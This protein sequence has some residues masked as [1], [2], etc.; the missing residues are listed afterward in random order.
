MVRKITDSIIYIGTDDYS[1]PKFESQ[2]MI[3][4]GMSFNSYLIK[5]KSIAVLDSCDKSTSA[6]WRN[7][8]LEALEGDS[9]LN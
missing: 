7:N 5:D 8:L 6:Q 4:D 2:Y 9:V 3:P 1:E